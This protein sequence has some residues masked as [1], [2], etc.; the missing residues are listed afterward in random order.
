[1]INK[2]KMK[3]SNFFIKKLAQSSFPKFYWNAT[4]YHQL[5]K[6]KAPIRR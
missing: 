2:E 5:S 4:L 6:S 3:N 1:M